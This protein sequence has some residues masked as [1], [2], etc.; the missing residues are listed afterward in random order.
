[1]SKVI[2]RKAEKIDSKYIKK[3]YDS[4]DSCF[5]IED[6]KDSLEDFYE[7][8]YSGKKG[9][10]FYMSY[11]LEN[12]CII[13]GALVFTID[14]NRKNTGI[15]KI[16]VIMYIFTLP[17]Y[18]NT[19][20]AKKVLN[21]LFSFFYDSIWFCEVLSKDVLKNGNIMQNKPLENIT[22][23]GRNKFWEIMGF[24][25]CKLDYYN[26]VPNL[27]ISCNDVISYNTLMC[28]SLKPYIGKKVFLK[29][30]KGYFMYGYCAGN[31]KNHKWA[32]YNLNKSQLEN[33]I[34]LKSKHW[35][36]IKE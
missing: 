20:L 10:S 9:Y 5:S 13:S 6:D 1:M 17:E 26:P 12:D 14:Y 3:F 29:F 21:H 4:Y 7:I 18:R 30:L 15:N 31:I 8:I 34:L 11:I 28:K 25:E 19:G 33:I 22:I 2:T 16:C 36:I 24:R 35:K 27:K 32:A 23:E